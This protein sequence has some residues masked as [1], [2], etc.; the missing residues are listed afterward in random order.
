VQYEKYHCVHEKYRCDHEKYR[1]NR[2][3]YRCNREKYQ[4]VRK[5]W[6]FR[7]LQHDNAI[8]KKSAYQSHCHAVSIYTSVDS[9]VAAQ[10]YE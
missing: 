3:K 9:S 2:E 4:C 5:K 1:C 6:L 10:T 8:V 7:C